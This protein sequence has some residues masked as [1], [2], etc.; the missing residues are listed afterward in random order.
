MNVIPQIN[1]VFQGSY[2]TAVRKVFKRTFKSKEE[3]H[4][5]LGKIDH[6]RVRKSTSTEVNRKRTGKNHFEEFEYK[7]SP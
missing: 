2:T 1:D 3:A 5:K 6:R 4:I 7:D